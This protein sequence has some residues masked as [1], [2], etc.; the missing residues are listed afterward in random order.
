MGAPSASDKRAAKCTIGKSPQCFKLQSRFLAI[1]GGIADERDALLDAVSQQEATC[2]EQRNTLEASINNDISL[3]S[4]SQTKLA[5]ATEKEATASEQARQT[6]KQNEEYNADLLQSMHKCSGN[7]VDFETEM[8]ALKKIRGELYKKT[9]KSAFFQD[10]EVSKWEPEECTKKCAGGEQTLTRSVLSPAQGGTE[11]LPLTAMRT[12]NNHPCPVDCQLHEW[13]GWNKCSSECGGGVQGRMRDVKVPMKHG[14][15]PC[16]KTT[17]AVAC[18][19]AAC[20]K[21]CELNEWTAWTTCSKDCDGGSQKRQKFIRSPAE[22]AGKCADEWG[23]GRLQYKKCNMQ[24]CTL[25]AG[26]ESIKCNRTM[27]V[28]LMIDECPKSGKEG[29][30]KQIETANRLVDAFVGP[31]VLS[32]PN[33]AIIKYCG[34]RTWSGVSKCDGKST[35]A[36]DTAEVCK[37]DIA[38]HFTES[39]KDVHSVLKGLEFVKG[40]KLVSLALIT[41]KGELAL[42]RKE[43]QSIVVTFLDGQ[44]LSFRKTRIAARSLRKSARVVW[45]VVSKFSPLK[46]VKTWATRRWQ[47]NLVLANSPEALGKPLMTT[48]IVADICP[49][50]A[51]KLKNIRP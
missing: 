49:K 16:G 2:E 27:D 34:P 28:I 47:E 22:G 30:Q 39:T 1:Q 40:T 25:P 19:V 46:D 38:Q 18:N 44:P 13:S 32:V 17:Q 8:C 7:Y 51:P 23:P 37:V 24:R 21:N 35:E 41:A 31:G 43:A 33:F 29:F 15:K 26:S 3:L 42:G 11:C 50:I 6:Y 20:E 10:C 9:G 12:C 4:S 48:H 45:V 5:T 36:V 14:G